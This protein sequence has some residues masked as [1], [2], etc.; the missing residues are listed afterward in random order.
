MMFCRWLRKQ[1]EMMIGCIYNKKVG[2]LAG[3]HE[4]TRY[5]HIN[6]NDEEVST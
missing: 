4:E 5:T 2:F 1:N 3:L 6:K